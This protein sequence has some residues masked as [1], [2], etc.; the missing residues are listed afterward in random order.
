V[1]ETTG[2]FYEIEVLVVVSLKM[3]GLQGWWTHFNILEKPV[4]SVIML[5]YTED[6]DNSF[7]Q[8]ISTQILNHGVTS[9][10]SIILTLTCVIK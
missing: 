4:A 1:F 2:C 8:N 9:Q 10:K 6:G 3:M 7:L 5:E